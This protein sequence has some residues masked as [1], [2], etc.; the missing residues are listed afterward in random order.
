MFT[1]WGRHSAKQYRGWLRLLHPVSEALASSPHSTLNSSSPLV[2][3][4]G[5][6]NCSS[7]NALP[8][9]QPGLSSH[10]LALAWAEN[11]QKGACFVS[12]AKKNVKGFLVPFQM[13]ARQDYL[14]QVPD[15]QH[16]KEVVGKFST[17]ARAKNICSELI[18]RKQE[19]ISIEHT[20]AIDKRG[21]TIDGMGKRKPEGYL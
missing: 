15:H 7:N 11:Q 8:C 12:K 21:R 19:I 9:T 18:R 4:L 20:L 3:M 13:L 2:G 5:S 14:R 16:Q 17:R 10:L 6:R 1:Y